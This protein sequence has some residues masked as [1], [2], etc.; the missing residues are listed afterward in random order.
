MEKQ[1]SIMEEIF[2]ES[3]D[4]I[5]SLLNAKENKST[6]NASTVNNTLGVGS[7]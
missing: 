3:V 1:G 4:D 5:I 6:C 7:S 2:T